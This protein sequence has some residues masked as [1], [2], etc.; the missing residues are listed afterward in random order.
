MHAAG[1]EA[2]HHVARLHALA[3]QDL[4]LFDNA[5]SK[6]R[7]VVFAAWI[8]AGHFGRFAADERATAEF[9]TQRDAADY[10]GSRIYVELAAGKIVEKKERLGALHQH[11]VDA[12]GDEVD[13]D[14]VVHLPFESQLELGA[15][16]VGAAH[17]HRLFIAL[18]HFEERA[19]AADARQYAFAHRLLRERFDALD[20]RVA[21]IDIDAGILVAERGGRRRSH[22]RSIGEEGRRET[23]AG[24]HCGRTDRIPHDFKGHGITLHW[25]PP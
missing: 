24:N 21:G 9:A 12:H 6:T 8:H 5:D 1:S 4:R 15:D 13:P 17:Q 23:G 16:A 11:V 3:G 20:Q 7:E 19:E 22:G 18:G 2:E 14:R 25:P 10:G